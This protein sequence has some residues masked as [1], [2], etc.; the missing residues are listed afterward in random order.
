MD[1]CLVSPP[2]ARSGR[3]TRRRLRETM[4]PGCEHPWEEHAGLADEEPVVCGECQ[5]EEDH[6]QLPEGRQK[7]R[8]AVPEEMFVPPTAQTRERAVA[9]HPRIFFRPDKR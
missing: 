9:V 6:E 2:L 8:N 5:F 3:A 4:C 1:T 7:C